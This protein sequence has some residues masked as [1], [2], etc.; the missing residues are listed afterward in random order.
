MSWVFV[1][2]FFSSCVLSHAHNLLFLSFRCLKH[3]A[4]LSDVPSLATAFLSF[5]RKSRAPNVL[6]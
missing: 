3:T 5:K 2:I 4:V 6:F 1:V